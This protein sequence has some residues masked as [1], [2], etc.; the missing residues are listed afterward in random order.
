MTFLKECP[1]LPSKNALFQGTFHVA[2][3]F[4]KPLLF[5]IIPICGC[6]FAKI[7]GSNDN[8]VGAICQVGGSR[9]TYANING[10]IYSPFQVKWYKD[11][12]LLDPTNNHEM[13][14]FG[15]RHVLTLKNVR[16]VDFGNYSCMADNS[17]GRERGS[18]EVSGKVHIYFQGEMNS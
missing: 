2:I 5:C 8:W 17:L 9:F 13:T 4:S 1:H 7:N 11:T 18:I 10:G 6:K 14:T 15:N 3:N 16:D 12:M